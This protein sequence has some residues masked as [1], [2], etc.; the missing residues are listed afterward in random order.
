M[1]DPEWT[2]DDR[3]SE[4]EHRDHLNSLC[5]GCGQPRHESFAPENQFAYS[6]ELLRCFGCAAQRRTLKAKQDA[7]N[8]DMEGIHPVVSKAEPREAT[9]DDD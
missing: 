3:N 2:D 5:P 7:D 9:P 1:R 4:M 8:F 6:V